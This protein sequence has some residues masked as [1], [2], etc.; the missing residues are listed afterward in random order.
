MLSGCVMQM[1]V[2]W[3]LQLCGRLDALRL[4]LSRCGGLIELARKDDESYR[5]AV[6]KVRL[7]ECLAI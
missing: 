3:H 2:A 4:G 5:W 6:L 7:T 1:L